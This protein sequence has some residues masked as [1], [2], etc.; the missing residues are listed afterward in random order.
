VSETLCRKGDVFIKMKEWEKAVLTFDE[1]LRIRVD[2]LPQDHQDIATC[3][4]KIANA[5]EGDGK[6]EQAFE[7]YKKAQRLISGNLIEPDVSAADLFYDL[8]NVVLTQDRA[9][10]NNICPIPTEEDLSLALTCLALARDTYKRI[11]GENALEVANALTL[12]GRIYY[13]Y[14]EYDV[15]M[16]AFEDALDI[17]SDAP[18]DQRIR[19]A[20]TLNHLGLTQFMSPKEVT[21]AYHT[22]KYF[23]LAQSI[24]EEKG[25]EINEDFADILVNKGVLLAQE[26][27]DYLHDITLSSFLYLCF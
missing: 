25:S 13:K 8:G 7:Y 9:S 20:N 14:K 5:Y 3:F 17:Y 16:K 6:L 15:A 12:M 23:N 26:G 1:A 10:E 11:F 24:Y 18:L 21:G 4:H 19:I 2:R 27:N 22:L